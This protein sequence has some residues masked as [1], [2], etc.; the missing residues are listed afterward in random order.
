MNTPKRSLLSLGGLLAVLTVVVMLINSQAMAAPGNAS[1]VL[2]QPTGGQVITALPLDT[3]NLVGS[4]RT[5]ELWAMAG[6]VTMPDDVV[7]PIWGFADN[8]AGP[9]QLPGPML[10]ANQGET[11]EII[12]HNE[13]PGEMVSLEFPGQP[14]LL[15]DLVGVGATESTSYSFPV[16]SPGTFLYE[17]GL[18][19]NGARQV[20]MGLYGALIVRPLTAGQAYDDPATAFDDEALLVL[21]EIDPD[22][23]NDPYGFEMQYYSPKYW[24]IN[25]K[26]YPQT[27]EIDTAADNTVLLRYINAG[28][29]SHDMGLLGL[30]QQIIASDGRALAWPYRVVAEKITSG[31][32]MDTLTTIPVL[33]ETGTRYA[34]Y[35][36]NLILHNA[37]EQIGLNG[38]VAYGGMM[39]FIHTLVGTTPAGPG[40]L[41]NPV[42]VEPSP[43]TGDAGVKLT[44]HLDTNLTSG[45]DIVAAEYFVNSAG[46]PGT[47]IAI[48]V[49][50]PNPAVTVIA[51]IGSGELATWASD[52]YVFY[53]R[54][55]DSADTWGPV[56][57]AV[58]NLDKMGPNISGVSL[59][60]DLTNGT[61]SVLLRATGDDRPNGD[62]PVVAGEYSIDGG[63]AVPMLLNPIEASLRAMTATLTIP[64][65]QSLAEGEHLVAITAEDWLGNIT[66]PAEVITLRLDQ[67]GPDAP[68]VTV[69]PTVL[70]LSGAPPVTHVRLDATISD[71][72]AAGVQSTLAN[73]EAFIDT[74]GADGTGFNIFPSDGLFDEVTED[75]YFEIPI[76][77]FLYLAQGDHLVYVHG[78]DSAGN[79]GT[80]GSATITIDRGVAVDTIGP[81][82]NAINVTP[83]PALLV[84]NATPALDLQLPSSIDQAAAINSIYVAATTSDPGLISN[85][86]QAEWFVDTDP[87]EGNG[88]ALVAADGVFDSTSETLAA[89][90]DISSWELRTYTLYVRA[91]DSSGNWGDP[92]SVEVQVIEGT[93]IYL[94]VVMR[95]H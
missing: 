13:L 2:L 85:I 68:S 74:V 36:S 67:T 11:L 60:P 95:N 25:G 86:A 38:P 27:A 15:P 57:S 4:T 7:V 84:V 29:E 3:C 83:N 31:Q 44:A 59:T 12:L 20:A 9:A 51:D 70:D 23:N 82:I 56:G 73:A 41:A 40:P 89:T 33:S 50:N 92:L 39:T 17:A 75:A 46:D 21:G 45:L 76:V 65:I 22:L 18:T 66:D 62:N 79:W 87:G 6:E 53:V 47:G 8:P 14:G 42:T 52:Y 94:P 5:C 71:A 64:T 78:L 10:I 55:K 37:S 58:L 19:E 80:V 81:V 49:N 93:A 61:E 30:R 48:P 34:L 72:L 26:A 28:L 1:G 35:Q 63:P 32:T 69:N 90:I 16:D 43:T 91:K 77:N 54:G 24:L 88:T